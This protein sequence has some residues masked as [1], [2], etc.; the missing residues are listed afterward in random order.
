MKNK[1]FSLAKEIAKKNLK[2]ARK[3]TRSSFVEEI[4]KGNPKPAHSSLAR[5]LAKENFQFSNT[6]SDN[7]A[8]LFQK[9][10]NSKSV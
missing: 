1:D 4:A 3:P 2:T 8:A 5:T 7:L 6:S 9:R 10:Q